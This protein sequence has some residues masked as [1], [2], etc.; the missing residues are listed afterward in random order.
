MSWV[1][2][3]AAI[4]LEICGTTRMKLSLGF[5]RFWPSVLLFVFYSLSF[6]A[7]ALAIKQIEVSV[8]YAIWSG[9]GTAM[10][11]T[12]GILWFKEAVSTL[13][14]VSLV[15]IVIGIVGLRLSGPTHSPTHSEDVATA[16]HDTSKAAAA[17]MPET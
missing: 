13:K 3:S 7:V 10:I 11:A 6:A 14:L 2:L 17:E 9:V 8:A 15:L 16:I 4:L 12:I 5:T 1:Y